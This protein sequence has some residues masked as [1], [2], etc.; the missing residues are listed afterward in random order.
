MITLDLKTNQFGKNDKWPLLY[1]IADIYMNKSSRAKPLKDIEVVDIAKNIYGLEI[2]RRTIRKYR[3][4]LEQYFGYTFKTF[5]KGKY[6]EV[7]WEI[8]I[9]AT[10]EK[11]FLSQFKEYSPNRGEAR[12][13]VR[14]ISIILTAQK[15]KKYLNV[16]IENYIVFLNPKDEDAK[17][18][19]IRKANLLIA[20]IEVFRY[21]GQHYLLSYVK[22]EERYYIHLIKSLIIKP[23]CI[24]SESF[25]RHIGHVN[26]AEYIKKQDFIVTGPINPFAKEYYFEL[27]DTW[28]DNSMSEF[29][30]IQLYCCRTDQYTFFPNP[31]LLQSLIDLYGQLAKKYTIEEHKNAIGIIFPNDWRAKSI[32]DKNT[33]NCVEVIPL[34]D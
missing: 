25:S 27:P 29:R 6:V 22:D 12:D 3:D 23:S 33:F 9:A 10:H 20:P 15:E 7:P 18:I 1:V 19:G 11:E 17:R 8:N 34:Y 5:N 28:L 31:Y 16:G 13:I 14:K 30:V 24:S 26:L 2:E 4:Y 21:E 32:V